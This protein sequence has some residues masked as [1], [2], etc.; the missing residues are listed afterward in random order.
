MSS[1][2]QVARE[3]KQLRLLFG[4]HCT[5]CGGKKQLEFAHIEPTGLDGEGRGSKER[6]RDIKKNKDKYE[7]LCRPC[8]KMRDQQS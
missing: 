5:K 6:M 3:M 4:G 7:L 1:K 2:G 8:H